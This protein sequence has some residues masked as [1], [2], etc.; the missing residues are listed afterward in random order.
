MKSNIVDLKC[1]DRDYLLNIY[2]YFWLLA[3]IPKELQFLIISFFL[4]I[5]ISKS[6]L[7]IKIVRKETFWICIGVFI[8]IV[9]VLIQALTEQ[10]DLQRLL[11]AMNIILIWI[12]SLLFYEIISRKVFSNSEKQ[13]LYKYILFDFVVFI[14]LYVLSLFYSNDTFNL[15]GYTLYLRKGDYLSTGTTS[16]YCA[17]M[18]T[19]LNPTHMFLLLTP[20]LLMIPKGKK[21][22][23]ISLIVLS[24]SYLAVIATH[25][26][27]G[28]IV[29]TLVYGAYF[30][31]F[32]TKRKIS[33]RTKRLIIFALFLLAFLF[34]ATQFEGIYSKFLQLFTQRAGS[35]R[36]RFEVYRLSIEKVLNESPIFGVGIKYI[37]S[38]NLLPYGSHCT[39]I[40]LL[41][42][43]G[44]LGLICF[45]IGFLQLCL[46]IFSNHRKEKEI[47]EI[48]VM[49]CAYFA[50]LIFAD[51]DG[52]NWV[53]VLAFTS[54]A[55]LQ[56]REG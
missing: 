56:Q 30:F 48:V 50:F 21:Q 19:P 32:L 42:K 53:I 41:Y 11:G 12:I 18:E 29:S 2:K 20:I 23:I 35:N 26:R 31:D 33:R 16:R 22:E 13:K 24:F 55:I 44:I 34:I 6:G 40:G 43:T 28:M 52:T 17:L 37:I 47:F 51:I 9:A 14:L 46:R 36:A 54:W 15:F 27:T 5:C 38:T 3:I 25:S 8:Q 7:N 10:P 1:K 45:M 49:I 4:L 39:Y